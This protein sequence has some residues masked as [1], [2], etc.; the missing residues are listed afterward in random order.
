MLYL[1]LHLELDLVSS[2]TYHATGNQ[3][4]LQSLVLQNLHL[5]LDLD[6]NS[7]L[8]LGSRSRLGTKVRSTHFSDSTLLRVE[9]LCIQ[10]LHNWF[11]VSIVRMGKVGTPENYSKYRIN[12]QIGWVRAAELSRNI[13]LMSLFSKASRHDN[14]RKLLNFC[15]ITV[16]TESPEKVWKSW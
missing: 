2:T 12:G 3:L 5:Y 14:T 11:P 7:Y 9:S 16:F 13:H 10:V 6:L 4:F 15:H 8:D 1:E